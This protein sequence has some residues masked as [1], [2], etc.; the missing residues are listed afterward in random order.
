GT[1]ARRGRRTGRARN[2]ASGFSGNGAGR[3][4]PM[5]NPASWPERG[6]SPSIVGGSSGRAGSPPSV[7]AGGNHHGREGQ[8]QGAHGL[9]NDVDEGLV[10]RSHAGR[11][12]ACHPGLPLRGGRDD[13]RSVHP[14]GYMISFET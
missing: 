6:A 1:R 3:R 11:N 2:W 9:T 4:E 10:A 13:N 8:A 7:M 5:K 12:K 14:I